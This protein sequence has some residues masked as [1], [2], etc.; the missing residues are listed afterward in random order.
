MVRCPNP[1]S[2]VDGKITSIHHPYINSRRAFSFIKW[3]AY[4]N[5]V[6]ML[7]CLFPNDLH[8]Q[9]YIGIIADADIEEVA[10]SLIT[11]GGVQ[12]SFI[13]DNRI[14][15][16]DPSVFIVADHRLAQVDVFHPAFVDFAYANIVTHAKWFE[17]NDKNTTD[18]VRKGLLRSKANNG[19]KY[20]GTGKQGNP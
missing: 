2:K 16:D 12:Y 9:V 4:I 1:C 17:N 10:Y 18:N 20:T 19:C 15:D 6:W 5:K 11:N 13:A 3:A 8:G 7:L 14:G